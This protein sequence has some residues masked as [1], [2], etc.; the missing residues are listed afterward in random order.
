MQVRLQQHQIAEA[1]QAIYAQSHLQLQAHLLCGLNF[2]RLHKCKAAGA[3]LLLLWLV[4]LELEENSI[5]YK[6]TMFICH[7]CN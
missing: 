4:V 2:I 6:G 3:E 7:V 1:R 5:A